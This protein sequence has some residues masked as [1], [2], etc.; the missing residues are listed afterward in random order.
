MD[1]SLDPNTN[2]VM[3]VSVPRDLVVHM[4]L[5][6]NAGSI[7]TNKINAAYEVPYTSIICCVAPQFQGRDGGG[8]AAEHEV[9]KVLGI[10]FDRYIAS[11]FSAFR[12][13]VNDLGGVTDS[14]SSYHFHSLNP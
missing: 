1:G 12:V 2:R 9:S 14:P 8:R 13:M 7:W 3:M 4:N 6:T 11:D 10:N 5:Q